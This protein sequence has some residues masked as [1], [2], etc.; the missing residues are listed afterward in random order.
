MNTNSMNGGSTLSRV[1]QKEKRREEILN[2]G[3]DLFIRKGLTATKIQDIAQAVG[4]S[5]GLL[6]HYFESKEQLYEELIRIGIQGPQ[7][8]MPAPDAEPL[9]YFET[10]AEQL[11]NAVKEHPFTAKM[12]VFVSQAMRDDSDS[13]TVRELLS[14]VDS[15]TPCI[16]LILEGQKNKTI[17]DGDPYALLIAFWSSIMGIA[18][19]IALVPDAQCPKAEWIVDIIRN[20]GENKK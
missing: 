12:F 5:V 9:K 6:F 16:P 2:A 13:S 17:R 19:M 4:M 18:E 1:K 3:L 7:S 14:Q 8:V 11:L 20:Q 15:I 10:V